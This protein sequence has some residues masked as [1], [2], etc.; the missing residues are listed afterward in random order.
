MDIETLD[1]TNERLVIEALAIHCAYPLEQDQNA[2]VSA[3]CVPESLTKLE[4]RFPK[5]ILFI[6]D[7]GRIVAIHW[8]EVPTRRL[9]Y[10]RSLWVDPAFRRRG[11]AMQLKQAGELW[12][13]ENN[14]REIESCALL[15]NERMVALNHKLG[16]KVVGSRQVKTLVKNPAYL[17]AVFS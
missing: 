3:F 10:A 11:L 4:A 9:G 14:V 2:D 5:T 6:Q 15:T 7:H 1:L 17:K 8:L 16:F 12:F 13:S